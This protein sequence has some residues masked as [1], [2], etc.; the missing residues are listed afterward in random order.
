MF[1]TFLPFAIEYVR[2]LE[3]KVNAAEFSESFCV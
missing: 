1:P 3:W 2:D